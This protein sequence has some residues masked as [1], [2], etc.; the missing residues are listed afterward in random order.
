MGF[1]PIWRGNRSVFPFTLLIYFGHPTYLVAAYCVEIA[2]Q[3]IQPI[4]ARKV[5]WTVFAEPIRFKGSY[6]ISILLFN[7]AFI[8][9]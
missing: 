3:L 2:I 9:I 4:S 5:Y 6:T 7:S 1:E 8:S